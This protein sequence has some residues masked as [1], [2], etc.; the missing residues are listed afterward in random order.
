[1]LQRSHIDGVTGNG[2][3]SGLEVAEEL[4][5]VGFAG[6]PNH[7]SAYLSR[8]RADAESARPLTVAKTDFSELVTML[9][10][11]EARIR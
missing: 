1:M 11:A 2:E 8:T 7:Y 9:R 4:R 5:A 10:L 6:L 3:T